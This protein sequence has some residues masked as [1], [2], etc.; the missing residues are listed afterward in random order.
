MGGIKGHIAGYGNLMPYKGQKCL[1]NHVGK[2]KFHICADA[3]L[4]KKCLKTAPP[5]PY[6]A[7]CDE[8]CKGPDLHGPHGWCRIE[9]FEGETSEETEPWGFCSATCSKLDLSPPTYHE[10]ADVDIL[11]SNRC[12]RLLAGKFKHPSAPFNPKLELCAGSQLF[13]NETKKVAN[14]LAE[15]ELGPGPGIQEKIVKTRTKSGE[16]F[17]MKITSDSKGNPLS[18]RLLKK[19]EKHESGNRMVTLARTDGLVGGVDACQGDSGGP[20][21]MDWANRAVQVG[22]VSQG[23]ACG[24]LN[25]PGVYARLMPHMDWIWN[26]T[27]Q[28]GCYTM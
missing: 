23:I 1:T 2:F 10:H 7:E 17:Y 9:L 27:S 24:A 6:K 14:K 11:P 20:L 3:G 26:I 8:N 28:Y 13:Q 4:Y 5:K 19:E 16:I 21:W 25:R 15:S 12:S 22:T 18:A